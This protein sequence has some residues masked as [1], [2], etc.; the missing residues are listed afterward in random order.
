MSVVIKTGV[1]KYKNEN[2]EYEDFNMIAQESTDQQIAS[3]ETAGQ[4]QVE[5][6]QQTGEDVLE[7]IPDDYEELS[8]DV[9]ELKSAIIPLDFQWKKFVKPSLFPNTLPINIFTDGHNF[10]TDYSFDNFKNTGGT[11]YYVMPNGASGFDGLT[12]ETAV[13]FAKAYSLASDGDTI[14]LLEGDYDRDSLEWGSIIIQKSIN[15]IGEGKCRIFAGNNDLQFTKTDGYSNVYQTTRSA[16]VRVIDYKAIPDELICYELKNS[17]TAVDESEGSYYIDS[18]TVYVHALGGINPGGCVCVTVNSER[19]LE[20][21]ND[22]QNTTVAF[23]NIMLIGKATGISSNRKNTSNNLTV[24]FDNVKA[25]YCGNN[26]NDSFQ[27]YGG[28]AILN[29]CIAQCSFKDGFNYNGINKAGATTDCFIIEVDCIGSTCG[30]LQAAE[31]QNGTTGHAGVKIIRVNGIYYDNFGANVA[32][33]QADT[34]SINLGCKAFYS[35]GTPSGANE[36]FAAQ[37]AGTTMWLYGCVGVGATKDLSCVTGSTMYID[38]CT[39]NVK[40][41]GGVFNEE[42]TM[43]F[44]IYTLYKIAKLK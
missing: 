35:A 16:A 6:I 21:N 7:S 5:L 11:T 13:S 44:D 43:S 15:I 24:V 42:N 25:I 12:K 40:A 31:S 23:Q 27:I 9:T 8:D 22:L 41:G 38:R 39:Y 17:I 18:S 29:A 32:D 3:I 36:N 37:Q 30:L 28:T 33:V 14:I 10:I 19:F 4:T 20:A 2:D 34:M 1:L 26:T